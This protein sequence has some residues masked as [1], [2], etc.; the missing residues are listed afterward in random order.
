LTDK[1]LRQYVNGLRTNTT[2]AGLFMIA[3]AGRDL[4]RSDGRPLEHQIRSESSGPGWM[5]RS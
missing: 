5:R 3:A 4:A 2:A 1:E